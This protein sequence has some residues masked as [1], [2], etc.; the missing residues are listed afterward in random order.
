MPEALETGLSGFSYYSFVTITTL[1]Y[2]DVTPVSTQARSL[3]LLEAVLGQLYIAILIARLVG[4]HLA[5]SLRRV[6]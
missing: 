1:G 4:S 2:G 3:A 6:P 5:Q